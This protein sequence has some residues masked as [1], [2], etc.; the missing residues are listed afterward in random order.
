MG[1]AECDGKGSSL[2]LNLSSSLTTSVTLDKVQLISLNLVFLISQ[3]L[4]PSRV[5]VKRK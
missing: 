4:P 1:A 3:I 2:D 5:H